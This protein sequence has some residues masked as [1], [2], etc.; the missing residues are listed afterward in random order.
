M[1]CVNKFW[2]EIYSEN[3]QPFESLHSFQFTFMYHQKSTFLCESSG[4]VALIFHHNLLINHLNHSCV[5]WPD[6]LL[7]LDRVH[8]QGGH[9]PGNQGTAREDEKQLK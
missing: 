2:G 7:N 5:H 3:C 9:C 1:K 8:A 4:S 6:G